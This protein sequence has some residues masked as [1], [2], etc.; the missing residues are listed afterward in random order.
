MNAMMMLCGFSEGATSTR[1]YTS[2]SRRDARQLTSPKSYSTKEPSASAPA[3]AHLL[4][5][6]TSLND[7]DPR[8]IRRL[9]VFELL[10]LSPSTSL[11]DKHLHLASVLGVAVSSVPGSVSLCHDSRPYRGARPV[12]FASPTG[13]TYQVITRFTTYLPLEAPTKLLVQQEH[14][15][16]PGAVN[17]NKHP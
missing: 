9:R 6:P 7:R 16:L 5:F 11:F 10:A 17:G 15:F 2:P 1:F 13:F 3:K 8:N 12:Y 4:T 14:P